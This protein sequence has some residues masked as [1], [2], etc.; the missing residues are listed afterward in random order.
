MSVQQ[1]S[2]RDRQVGDTVDLREYLEPVIRQKRLILVTALVVLGVACTYT[3]TRPSVYTST[4]TVLVKPTGVNLADL[5]PLGTEKLVNVDTEMQIVRSTIVAE[6]AVAAMNTD[7]TAVELLKHV[8]VSAAPDAQT[9]EISFSGPSPSVAQQGTA[10]FADAYLTYRQQQAQG[11]VDSQLREINASLMADQARV[12]ELNAVIASSP[13]DSVKARNAQTE[14]N[15]VL[16]S[17]RRLEGDVTATTLLNTDPGQVISDAQVPK[18]P[19]GPNR[20]LDV[21]LGLFLGLAAGIVVASVRGRMDQRLRSTTDLEEV[22]GAPLLAAIPSVPGGGDGPA[23]LVV[24]HD[25]DA[26]ASEA[27]RALRTT[28]MAV[29][30][31]DGGTLLVASALPGEGKTTVAANLSAAL[32]A[33]GKRV[34]LVSADMRRPRAH[35]LFGLPNDRGLS[36]ILTGEALA[37]LRGLD[38]H[39]ENLYVC[40]SGPTPPN[41]VELLQSGRMR[42]LLANLRDVAEYIVLDCP[43]VLTVAD[44]LVLASLVDGV[45]FVV[46]ASSTDRGAVTDA[47]HRLEQ[48]GATVLGGVLNKEPAPVGGMYGYGYAYGYADEGIGGKS[49]SR[50]A[51]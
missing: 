51:G 48:V 4:A 49:A 11:L 41:P 50:R 21:A 31:P 27:Y 28:L 14:R 25:P 22:L 7:A 33:V 29:T 47:R 1:R 13:S 46:D 32:A 15:S 8:S 23:S 5:G 36:N 40:P 19:S 39:V 44:P 38:A 20:L 30:Q 18:H 16:V 34:V 26:P 3:F 37:D 17:I 12:R 2:G 6:K 9:L 43:P 45:V 42:D 10:A 35:E 24:T